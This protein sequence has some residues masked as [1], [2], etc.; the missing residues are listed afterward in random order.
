M[1]LKLFGAE[2]RTTRPRTENKNKK[3]EK[4][5]RKGKRQIRRLLVLYSRGCG[6]P[7]ERSSIEIP[8]IAV[9]T[10][11][12]RSMVGLLSCVRRG[13]IGKNDA[14]P[15]S[16]ATVCALGIHVT[17]LKASGFA[18]GTTYIATY[19]AMKLHFFARL[20]I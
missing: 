13:A 7:P 4:K 18:L 2:P 16:N 9:S 1:E 5:R 17:T 19:G 3:Q 6:K 11:S 12:L 15:F 8:T 10:A 20:C 14:F